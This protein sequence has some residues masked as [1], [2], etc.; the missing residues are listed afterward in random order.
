MSDSR[1]TLK[2]HT[3]STEN[4]FDDKQAA[5]D[6]K[7]LLE[8]NGKDVELI[9]N[10]KPDGGTTPE[11][12]DTTEAVASQDN[13]DIINDPAKLS[14]DPIGWLESINNSFVNTIR[15][16]KAISKRGFRFMQTELGISTTS[17]VVST[18]ED[19][20][21]VIIHARAEMPN[22]RC[23]E[24]HGEGYL[25]EN[26]VSDNEFVRYADSRAKSRAISDLTAAGALSESELS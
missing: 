13:T 12:V 9:D 14:Q 6:T 23:A 11:V 18:F 10:R 1:Y 2:N 19:P 3:D 26:D 25:N 7:D 5:E 17:E 21:G 15:G 16:N 20:R 8:S 22:G 4:D 24:A